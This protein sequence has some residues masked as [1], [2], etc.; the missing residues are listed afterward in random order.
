MESGVRNPRCSHAGKIKRGTRQTQNVHSPPNTKRYRRAPAFSISVRTGA[1]GV[2]PSGE[3]S[4]RCC[5]DE[6]AP[7]SASARSAFTDAAAVASRRPASSMPSSPSAPSSASWS[8]SRPRDMETSTMHALRGYTAAPLDASV[9]CPRR[10]QCTAD[11][12]RQRPFTAVIGHRPELRG[13][14]WLRRRTIF[15]EQPFHADQT[16]DLEAHLSAC[17]NISDRFFLRF[18]CRAHH[19]RGSDSMFLKIFVC[20]ETNVIPT[21]GDKRKTKMVKRS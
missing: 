9:S 6:A 1:S 7:A 2:A 10:F 11:V 17:S 3:N 20:V 8:V 5:C 13:L 21:F 12:R 16:C 19:D 15:L 14:A 4:S 18:D